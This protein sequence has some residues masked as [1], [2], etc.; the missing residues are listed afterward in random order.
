MEEFE[1]EIWKSLDFLGYPDYEISTLGR[2]KSLER[3]IIRKN[4]IKKTYSERILKPQNERDYQR[5]GLWKDRKIK[6]FRVH[7]LVALA[8][9]PNPE[10][11]PCINHKDENPSNNHINNLEWCDIRYNINYGLRNEK[12]GKRISKTK[13]GKPQYKQRKPI[14]QYTLL[15]EFI[16]EFDSAKS[17]SENLNIYATSITQ[18]CKGKLKTCGGY[19]W[20]YKE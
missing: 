12:A 10:K 2:V 5:V 15:G 7:R 20:K 6:H 16:K 19:I 11:L 9:I 18:C 4:G 17:A 13:K 1:V 14:L 3:T 8:F